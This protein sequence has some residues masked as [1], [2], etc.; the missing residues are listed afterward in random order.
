ML[1]ASWTCNV[2]KSESEVNRQKRKYIGILF[3]EETNN[4]EAV[5]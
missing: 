5:L 2:N 3:G 4:S 1:S